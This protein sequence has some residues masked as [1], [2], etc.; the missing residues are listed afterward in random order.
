MNN[1]FDTI[2]SLIYYAYINLELNSDDEVYYR[3]FILGELGINTYIKGKVDKAY[4]ESLKVPD[5]LILRLCE[6]LNTST[7][8]SEIAIDIKLNKILGILTP[9]NSVVNTNFEIIN[10]YEGDTSALEYLYNLSIKNDYV[11]KT[12]I[13]KNIL[14]DYHD[15]ENLIE[16]SINLS[17]PEKSNKDI[18]K[19]L[20]VNK[21][22]VKYPLCQL[23]YE[24]L[25]Y[26]GRI[27]HPSRVNLRFINIKLNNEEWA[28]Q[29]SPYGYFFKHAIAFKKVHSNMQTNKDTFIR[30]VE[31]VALFPSFFVGSNASLPIVGGSILNHEHYQGGAHILPLMKAK[32]RKEYLMNNYPHSKLY[33]LDWYNS[34]ILIKST[35][36][37]EVI[38]LGALINKAWENY[39]DQDNEIIN[40]SGD[41]LHNAITPSIRKI[42]DE[43][44]LYLILRNNRT[45][46]KHPDGIF[47]A[48]KEYHH[49]KAEG[50]GIIE[51]MG[52]FI[53]PARLERQIKEIKD[54]LASKLS[55]EEIL[56]KYP[57]LDRRFLE[58][59]EDLRKNYHEETIDQEI[60]DYIS[61]IC[62]NILLNTAVYKKTTEGDRGFDKFIGGLNL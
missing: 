31:F 57:T 54:S 42:D 61:N 22:D 18:A 13:E 50:I 16:V 5:E 53:L 3:N 11:K 30:L 21:N 26:Y 44:Y 36:K 46:D 12:F 27:D 39:S 33:R 7:E 8:E 38:A 28:L 45:N 29:Y 52:L 58:M 32:T 1:I 35:S 23:C 6:Y 55:D 41:L 2:D 56:N 48:H 24:N 43:Y 17:K 40:K 37:E 60:R 20:V 15:H 10:K 9:L 19:A 51:A 34:A 4:I 62:K 14:W 49:I 59:V 47:H 25:G